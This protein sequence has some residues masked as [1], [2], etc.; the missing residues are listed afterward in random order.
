MLSIQGQYNYGGSSYTASASSS[1]S[2]MEKCRGVATKILRINEPTCM[3]MK[4]TFGGIWNGGG[5]DG[6]KNLFVASFFFDRAAE[7]FL[8]LDVLRNI[9]TFKFFSCGKMNAE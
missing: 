9:S 8:A 5:G 6:Q 1:G 2:S 3:H 7:V 4:C